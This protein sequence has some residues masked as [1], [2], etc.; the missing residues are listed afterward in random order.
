MSSLEGVG[1]VTILGGIG[2]LSTLIAPP[3]EDT[4]EYLALAD[5][6]T[7]SNSSVYVRS[8]TLTINDVDLTR[9]LS[10]EVRIAFEE[11]KAT[12]CEFSLFLNYANPYNRN[13]INLLEDINKKVEYWSNG[14]LVFRG[15][16]EFAQA[17]DDTML[18]AY[19]ATT[20]LQQYFLNQ[21]DEMKT[22][23]Q[24]RALIG[25]K[26]STWVFGKFREQNPW[27]RVMK[28][29][30]TT[31]NAIYLGNDGLPVVYRAFASDTPKHVFTSH[32]I[33]DGSASV[34]SIASKESLVNTYIA[35]VNYEYTSF[36][37]Y[38]TVLQYNQVQDIN[39]WAY[40][41]KYYKLATNQMIIDAC[42]QAGWKIG[43]IPG[44]TPT[45][46]MPDSLTWMNKV[47]IVKE[48]WTEG[49][50]GSGRF[51]PDTPRVTY[52]D[53]PSVWP[54]WDTENPTF[55]GTGPGASGILIPNSQ[56]TATTLWTAQNDV[57]GANVPLVFRY[58]RPFTEEHKL[59]IQSTASITACG[60]LKTTSDYTVQEKLSDSAI[61]TY[62]ETHKRD[63]QYWSNSAPISYSNPQTNAI[64]TTRTAA[65]F[66][67]EVYTN[68]FA[69]IPGTTQIDHNHLI[70]EGRRE[71]YETA[72]GVVTLIGA[73][74]IRISHR[75][76][77]VSFSVI[78][79]RP[80]IKLGD[81]VEALSYKFEVRGV[82]SKV[83]FICQVDSYDYTIVTLAMS[84][85]GAAG[86]T[87]VYFDPPNPVNTPAQPPALSEAPPA[88]FEVNEHEFPN[89]PPAIMNWDLPP[90][91][92]AG[93]T[94]NLEDYGYFYPSN[95]EDSKYEFRMYFPGLSHEDGDPNNKAT[96]NSTVNITHYSD[97]L[98]V[99]SGID[100]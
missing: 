59:T 41:E 73:N 29:L 36:E 86:F 93:G 65:Q 16:V 57:I 5:D 1:G 27:D 55:E 30:S 37:A 2:E 61:K 14:V 23:A 82:V 68:K 8:H 71:E 97:P 80:E 56:Q 35:T 79:I 64:G 66:S 88:T 63:Y 48:Y 67:A 84:R 31:E 52:P 40:L 95:R 75:Q 39:S 33:I 18:V 69:L 72:V 12:T 50:P 99:F 21:P 54:S 38:Q 77:Y 81:T 90:L 58:T 45:Y 26:W 74:A 98:K 28:L 4:Q 83:Q 34:D 42:M 11:N 60:V 62:T 91:T 100:L 13:I 3:A 22:Y 46:V 92:G 17:P 51:A 89:P 15:Y 6:P 78:G 43:A 49:E 87:P 19:T 44:F 96:Y 25:G 53:Y 20:K 32:T 70:T 10:T 7:Y 24:Y 47:K 9:Y 76:N 94:L 85:Y